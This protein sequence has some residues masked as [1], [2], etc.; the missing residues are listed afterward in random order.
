MSVLRAGDVTQRSA[1]KI[2][3]CIAHMRVNKKPTGSAK[4]R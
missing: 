3:G 1:T 4:T 2:S